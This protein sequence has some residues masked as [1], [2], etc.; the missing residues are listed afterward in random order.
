MLK[1]N[2]EQYSYEWVKWVDL[3]EADIKPKKL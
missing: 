3:I 2:A 1:V